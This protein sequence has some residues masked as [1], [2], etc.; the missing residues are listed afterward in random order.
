MNPKNERMLGKNLETTPKVK[1]DQVSLVAGVEEF[2]GDDKAYREWVTNHPQGF[3]INTNR[4]GNPEY[5]VLHKAKCGYVSNF[6]KREQGAFTERDL[7]KVCST[8]VDP[9]RE[10]AKAHG[11]LDGSFTG[12]CKCTSS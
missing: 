5:M 10:W 7:M 12:E 1:A 8:E 3:V 11:R 4:G 6:D 2:S 9:L